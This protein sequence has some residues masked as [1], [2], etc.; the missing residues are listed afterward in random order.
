MPASI[1][2]L[3]FILIWL[4]MKAAVKKITA[5]NINPMVMCRMKDGGDQICGACA[6]YSP[7]PQTIKARP[8][9]DTSP[10]NAR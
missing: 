7:K 3:S 2:C 5:N 1:G 8:A 9:I 6:W 10:N 4:G